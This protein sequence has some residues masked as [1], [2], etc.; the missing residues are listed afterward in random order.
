METE[1]YPFVKAKHFTDVK[2][3][4]VRVVVLHSME[5]PEKGNTAEAVAN[6]FKR[7]ER[8]VSAHYSIDADSIIQCVWDTDVAWAAPGANHDGIQIEQ[9]GYARQSRREW[10][11]PYS[12]GTIDNAARVAAQICIKYDL[13]V[14]RLTDAELRAGKKGIVDHAQVSRVYK[15][16]SHTDCGPEYPWDHFLARARYWYAYY[17]GRVESPNTSP[18]E[19][20]YAVVVTAKNEV[21]QV[22][23]YLLGKKFLFKYLPWEKLPDFTLGYVVAIGA[24][25]REIVDGHGPGYAIVGPSRW[26][27]AELVLAHVEGPPPDRLRPWGEPVER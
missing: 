14:E 11:D 12:Q 25:A 19:P 3:R 5:A 1:T 22:L 8:K 26:A 18:Y 15:R 20:D 10:L 4:D 7:G 21:D 9:A 13:P 27:T 16:S 17:R 2:S 6:Y 23:A 24:G